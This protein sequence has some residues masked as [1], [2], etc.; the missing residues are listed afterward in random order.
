VNSKKKWIRNQ[1]QK[2]KTV[3]QKL[4]IIE[5]L[6]SGQLQKDVCKQFSIK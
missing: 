4:E 1:K 3:A 2:F 5:A 6:E